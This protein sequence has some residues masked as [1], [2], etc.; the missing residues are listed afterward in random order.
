MPIDDRLRDGLRRIADEVDPDVER[1]FQ[2]ATS[3]RAPSPVRRAG[4]VLAYA[5]AA[6]LGMA[7]IGVGASLLVD[8]FGMSP[9]P[10][11][12]VESASPSANVCSDPELPTC[13]GPLEPG[14]HRSELFIPPIDYIIP[15][16]SPVA[17]DNPEDRPGTF[18]LHPAGPDTDAIFFFRDVRVL[19][20][21]CNPVINGAVGNT[22]AEIADWME[23]NPG[24]I[25]TN[26][27]PVTH[28]GLRG[29]VLDLAASGSYTTVCPNDLGTYP[30]GLPIL[31]LLFGAGSGELT[32]FI[33]GDERMRLYLLDMPGGGN[34][35]ISI[36]AI[37]TDFETLLEVTQRVVD[38]ITFDEDYY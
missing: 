5:A 38:G 1:G 23:G 24:L 2:R 20:E 8:R 29:V 11:G 4:T 36:D 32:W 34:L 33:G 30:E 25:T 15:L 35:A 27:Q 18:T 22:A 16:D 3:A 7:V 10:G 9:T 28:G 37:N 13:A 19:T 26:V 12:S 31:P 21:G 14:A 6:V 17:W